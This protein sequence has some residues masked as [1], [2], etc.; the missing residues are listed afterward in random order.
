LFYVSGIEFS[1]ATGLAT[2]EA[3][4]EN[5]FVC[6]PWH[7]IVVTDFSKDIEG[8]IRQVWT[9]AHKARNVAKYLKKP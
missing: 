9:R 2:D 1:L 3:F 6:N 5:C 8:I 4:R 7:P